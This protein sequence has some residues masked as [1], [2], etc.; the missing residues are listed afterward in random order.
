[1]IP[2]LYGIYGAS[3][4]GREVMPVLREQLRQQGISHMRFSW[5]DLLFY[6]V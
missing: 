1:M 6:P 4:F 2:D 3:G 5:T